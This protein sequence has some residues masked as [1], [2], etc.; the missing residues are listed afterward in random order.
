MNLTTFA[1]NAT[2]QYC[3]TGKL[4]CTERGQGCGMERNS[5][6]YVSIAIGHM[7]L[8]LNLSNPCLLR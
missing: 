4:D 7:S 2:V 8:G 6:D 5:T 1:A 3:A